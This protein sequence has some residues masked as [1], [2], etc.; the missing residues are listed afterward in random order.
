[1]ALLARHLHHGPRH[2]HR[3]QR[4]IPLPFAHARVLPIGV[5][6]V[7]A[8]DSVQ[9]GPL[10][11]QAWPVGGDAARPLPLG[12]VPAPGAAAPLCADAFLCLHAGADARGLRRGGGGALPRIQ[13]HSNRQRCNC[14]GVRRR[15]A[16]G[17]EGGRQGP[18]PARH[19]HHHAG[20]PHHPHHHSLAGEVARGGMDEP[21]AGDEHVHEQHDQPGEPSGGGGEPPDVLEELRGL[22]QRL[23]PEACP[24]PLLRSCA[25]GELRGGCAHLRV[26]H[27]GEQEGHEAQEGAGHAWLQHLP[28][29]DL[30]RQPHPR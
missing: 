18:P 16:R 2:H 23:L 30:H 13:P 12:H 22:P 10:H 14:P 25:G 29:D 27:R 8:V 15:H 11:D 28:Q 1:M 24:A 7:A 17:P 26:P 5:D 4:R 6:G 19:R 9:D 21:G 20:P 3:H